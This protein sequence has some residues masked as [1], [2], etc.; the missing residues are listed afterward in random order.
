MR[1]RSFIAEK[2][3][4]GCICTASLTSRLSLAFDP[5]GDKQ[6]DHRRYLSLSL[7]LA[8]KLSIGC[9]SLSHFRALFWGSMRRTTRLPCARLQLPSWLHYLGGMPHH[10]RAGVIF[11]SCQETTETSGK[12]KIC[13]HLVPSDTSQFLH[14]ETLAAA[15]K[16]QIRKRPGKAWWESRLFES[17]FPLR[18]SQVGAYGY[19]IETAGSLAGSSIPYCC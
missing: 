18:G 2:S 6:H 16:L 4:E 17:S 7:L 12:T 10:A 1:W 11:F 19:D 14:I 8:S 15:S 5:A 3:G 13:I 9:F